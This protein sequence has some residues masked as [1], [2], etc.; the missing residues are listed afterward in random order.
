VPYRYKLEDLLAIL[1]DRAPAKADAVALQRRR[2]EHGLLSVGLKIHDL[3]N[4]SQ[5]FSLVERLGGAARILEINMYKHAQASLCLVLPPVGNARAAI[6]LLECIERFTGCSLFGNRKIQ[7][8]VCSPGRLDAR[9]SALLAIGFYLGSDTLRRY[10]CGDLE[11]TVSRDGRYQRG[12]RLVIYDAGGGFDRGFEWWE[13]SSN[14][15]DRLIRPELPFENG[16]ND[17]LTGN[18]SRLDIENINLLATL[19]IHAQY[20]GY[21]SNLG[22][23]FEADMQSLL[24]RHLLA[25]LVNAPWVHTGDAENVDDMTFFSALQEL[26]AYAFEESVR[27]KKSS[28]IFFSRWYEIPA[29]S[30]RGI[31]HE[32]Q[33]LLKKY[34]TEVVRQSRLHDNGG[35][36]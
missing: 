4:G 20:Q 18:S 16:R 7:I 15:R 14:G 31:L 8:Q 9:R 36:T 12:Q 26:V 23:R 28:G 5:F 6:L 24:D 21:W 1:H 17:L 11:T 19:L 2:V 27:V 34:R 30:S 13:R 33:S 3:G 25:G 29:R 22:E 32:M 35:C 10:S